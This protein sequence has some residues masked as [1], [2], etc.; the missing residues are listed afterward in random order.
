MIEGD[1][2]RLNGETSSGH[3]SNRCTAFFPNNNFRMDHDSRPDVWLVKHLGM[4]KWLAN[5][6]EWL[7]FNSLKVIS[8]FKR[9]KDPR[10]SPCRV[11]P[12]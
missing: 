1:Q 12:R 7:G 4:S 5:D 9:M 3:Y 6:Q 2:T 10:V 11:L 8:A